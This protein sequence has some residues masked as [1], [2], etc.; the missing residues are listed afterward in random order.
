MQGKM[1]MYNIVAP[2]IILIF[3]AFMAGCFGSPSLADE[4]C[5]LQIPPRDSAVSANHGSFFFVY[6]R[7]FDRGYSGCQTMWDELGRMVLVFHFR[8]GALIEYTLAD[9]STAGEPAVCK[10]KDGKPGAVNPKNCPQ[11]ADVENGL[12]NVLPEDEPEVPLERDP[13]ARAQR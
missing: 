7:G 8:D 11:F 10:Y 13:R 4:N 3:L 9:H 12:L 6:P 1:V 5:S 2:R